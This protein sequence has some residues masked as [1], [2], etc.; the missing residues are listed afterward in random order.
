MSDPTQTYKIKGGRV[1][2]LLVHGLC[3]SP[4]QMRFVAHG[5]ARQGY[6]VHCPTLAGHADGEKALKDSTWQDWYK[7]V[8]TAMFELCKDCDVV[9]A[10]GHS[11][12][13]LL[14]LM[15]AANHPKT[16]QSLALFAPTLWLNG[17]VVPW[18][19]KFFRA[20][21]HKRIANMINFPDVFPHGIKDKRVRDMVIAA[22]AR[23]DSQIGGIR[24]RP[25]GVILEHRRLVAAL[26][27]VIGRISQPAL[28]LH[29]RNDDYADLNNAYFLQEKLSGNVELTVLEDSYHIVTLDKE[30]HVVVDKTVSF[31]A[32]MLKELK[33]PSAHVTTGNG[34][35]NLPVAV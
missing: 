25:G 20:V 24:N 1:G 31:V 11:T 3:G 33:L 10:S 29:P 7:S 12:G 4:A 19:A 2:V 28:I 17:W 6:T 8:E 21:F 9:I 23:N 15:L 35:A 30:R 34:E 13:A 32:R 18:Y 27:K 26:R 22:L 5:L 16:V 14:T